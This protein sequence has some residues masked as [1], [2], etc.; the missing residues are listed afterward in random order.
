MSFLLLFRIGGGTEDAH[1]L[2][3]S[4]CLSVCR[5]MSDEDGLPKTNEELLKLAQ[6]KKKER[7]SMNNGVV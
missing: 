3:L 2:S 6:G 4:V 1:A 5:S 7:E